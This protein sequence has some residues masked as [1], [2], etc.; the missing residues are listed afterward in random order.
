MEH[1]AKE[2]SGDD[3]KAGESSKYR[4]AH[5]HLTVMYEV[6][7]T[8]VTE[9][10][11][12]TDPGHARQTVDMEHWIL[13]WVDAQAEEH[14]TFKLWAQFLVEDYPAYLALRIG[15]RTGGFKLHLAAL[16]QGPISMAR[17][18]AP[19]RCGQDDGQRL[20]GAVVTFLHVVERGCFLL[21]RFGREAGGREQ[22]L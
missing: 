16:R 12:R 3:K 22:T 6:F 19:R 11:Y 18:R 15:R 10:Y 7:V 14:Q 21:L 13:D 5:D 2:L 20:Q 9:K 17:Y 8:E 1:L 4:R